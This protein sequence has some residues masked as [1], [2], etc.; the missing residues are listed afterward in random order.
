MLSLYV[1][2]FAKSLV[3]HNPAGL[4]L[5][6]ENFN[7]L[8]SEHEIFKW[9]DLAWKVVDVTDKMEKG[10]HRLTGSITSEG[11]RKDH[12]CHF[13]K[14]GRREKAVER[15]KGYHSTKINR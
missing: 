7:H 10:E 8:V 1:I 2:Y 12:F 15:F 11:A 4:C 14:K 9:H 13:C 3:F 6:M 5:G